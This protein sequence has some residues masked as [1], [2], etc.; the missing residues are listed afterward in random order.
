MEFN[1]ENVVN[2][3]HNEKV[4]WDATVNGSEERKELA[5]RRST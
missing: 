3:V 4:L 5:W 2:A 1:N